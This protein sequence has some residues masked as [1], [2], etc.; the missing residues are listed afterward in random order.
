MAKSTGNIARVG[1]LLEAGV[2]PR[3]LRYALIAVH[4][5][6]ALDY[7][8]RVAGRRRGRARAA[9]RRRRR[10][11]R[12]SRGPAGRLRRCRASWPTAREAFGAALDDDL[13]VSAGLA[14]VFDLVRE[15]QPADRGADRCRPPMPR[16]ASRPL[17]DL[18]QVLGVLPDART[19]LLDRPGGAARR[20]SRRPR[21]PRLGGVGPTARRA[22]RAGVA[23]EDTRD[24]Q[25]WR[26]HRRGEPWLTDRRT[27][28]T[29]RGATTARRGRAVGP[30]PTAAARPS[31][32]AVGPGRPSGRTA[33]RRPRGQ[34]RTAAPRRS[35]RDRWRPTRRPGDD[36]PRPADGPA[37]A[38]ARTAARP[39]RAR[40]GPRRTAAGR[41]WTAARR[42]APGDRPPR[43]HGPAP[44]GRSGAAVRPATIATRRPR[45]WRRRRPT[46]AA[47]R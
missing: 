32:R 33:A 25:R 47:R 38:P 44:D 46:S 24:G 22:G 26:R 27:T 4:Y 7:S 42:A 3:A 43:R 11:R 30:R 17:R 8:R 16:G 6:A 41:G 40:E 19:T 2:S 5:R 45:P 34:R 15:A 18:D 10:P 29:G 28:A 20:A 9:R 23:V 13:N 37:A 39:D 14:V 31:G 35:A 12:V 1:E 21:G 36:R